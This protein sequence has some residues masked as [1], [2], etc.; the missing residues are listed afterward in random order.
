MDPM[1]MGPMSS[2]RTAEDR[3]SIIRSN[4][5]PK[6]KGAGWDDDKIRVYLRAEE[7]VDPDIYLAPKVAAQGSP[8]DTASAQPSPAGASGGLGQAFA[9]G[10]VQGLGALADMNPFG[11][12]ARIG[13]Q[14]AGIPQPPLGPT[15]A[16]QMGLAKPGTRG[17]RL[18]SAAAENV[19]TALPFAAAGPAGMLAK[20]AQVGVGGLAG[21]AGQE[22]VEQGAGEFGRFL[23][24]LGVGGGL[25][26]VGYL[27]PAFLRYAMAGSG[28]AR[29]SAMQTLATIQA[30]NPNMPVTLGQVAQGGGLASKAENMLRSMPAT[31]GTFVKALTGQAQ[32][33]EG[34]V[35]GVVAQAASPAKP[36]MLVSLQERAGG[37]VQRGIEKGFIPHW[38]GTANKLYD[39]VFAQVPTDAVV[40]PARLTDVLSE[41]GFR[42]QRAAPFTDD[43]VPVPIEKLGAKL[44]DA[45]EAS[46]DGLPIAAIKEFRSYVGEKLAGA[47]MV[48]NV[49]KGMWKQVY[50][51]LTDDL[52]TGLQMQ[53][54]QALGAFDRATKF[55]KAG[56]ERIE[57][58][59]QPLIDKKTPE[60]A[61]KLM[62]S[63]A[64]DGSSRLR[65]IMR[66]VGHEERKVVA[67][68]V[69]SEMGKAP[70]SA[71][72]AL[73][74]VWD[75]QTFMTKWATASPEAKTALFGAVDPQFSKNLDV[76]AKS[77]ADIRRVES[78][79]RNPLTANT[80]STGFWAWAKNRAASIIGSVA[81]AAAGVKMGG[82]AGLAGGA[83]VGSAAINIVG[84][85]L[86][87]RV[88]TNPKTVHWLVRQSRVPAG[89]LAQEA[90]ILLKDVQKWSPEDREVGEALAR[91]ILNTDW[92]S[93]LMRQ[94]VEDALAPGAQAD[95]TGFAPGWLPSQAPG[96]FLGQ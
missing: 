8:R 49:P 95:T 67:S 25:P 19:L 43:L 72:N 5:V 84:H 29:Q 64:S 18:A 82:A 26:M 52:R 1:M 10:A 70:A 20:A 27:G 79:M 41:I 81:G 12:P 87:K 80:T 11:A 38:K 93:V 75:I 54:P 23:A 66:S 86:T 22:A 60:E 3:D 68:S 58:F 59:L 2:A 44:I 89:A 36:G 16:D 42:A 9:R 94:S 65:A 14:V 69:L 78:T 56:A 47:D 24:S 32:D 61:F 34:R 37:A 46:P 33:I 74:D 63:G 39:D 13:A 48:E 85:Q 77:I 50:G 40:V 7:G 62:M 88:F 15:T 91:D 45:L 51:A 71:Q 21:V 83:L 28:S 55:Y 6:L 17:E 90:T 57:K 4:V 31:R 53:S 96:G 73:G 92:K 30:G 76:L 35:G